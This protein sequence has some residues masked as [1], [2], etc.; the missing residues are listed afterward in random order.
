M[1]EQPSSTLRK[2]QYCTLS[3]KP[4]GHATHER[5]CRQR[6]NRQLTPPTTAGPSHGNTNPVPQPIPVNDALQTIVQRQRDGGVY[7]LVLLSRSPIPLTDN[8]LGVTDIVMRALDV[9]SGRESV[10]RPQTPV[11]NIQQNQDEG[12]IEGI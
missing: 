7:F 2:C 5:Y 1:T 8:A 10:A 4:Q 12:I 9:A 3:F 11:R 6:Q